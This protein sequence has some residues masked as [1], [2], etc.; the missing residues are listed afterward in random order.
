M[1][2]SDQY[3]FCCMAKDET[4]D[5]LHLARVCFE[6][7]LNIVESDETDYV[8]ICLISYL[9]SSFWS[10]LI[11]CYGHAVNPL[12][13]PFHPFREDL[14]LNHILLVYRN[15]TT[16]PFSKAVW[17]ALWTACIQEYSQP[18]VNIPFIPTNLDKF[19]LHAPRI[20]W[21]RLDITKPVFHLKME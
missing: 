12:F 18:A 6:L 21:K 4:L 14:F 19:L 5:Q 17:K 8:Y 13:P 9:P 11:H 10:T 16:Q 2:L 20:F 15:L 7:L 1:T 3:P